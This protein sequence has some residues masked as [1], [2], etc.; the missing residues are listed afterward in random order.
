MSKA[1]CNHS[2]D[3]V[4][5][6]AL[7]S[8]DGARLASQPDTAGLATRLAIRR[9]HQAHVAIDPLLR[10]TGLAHSQVRMPDTRVGVASQIAF[11]ERAARALNDPFLGFRLAVECDLR[12]VGL[13]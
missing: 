10:G 1:K 3:R 12:E 7:C 9:L 13:L 4:G 2:A 8:P 11:L 5:E 6:S